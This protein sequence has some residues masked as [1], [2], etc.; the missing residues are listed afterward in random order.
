M[1]FRFISSWLGRTSKAATST[2]K[3]HST[4]EMIDYIIEGSE[5]EIAGHYDAAERAFRRALTITPNN[6]EALYL[7]GKQMARRG[8]YAGSLE[9]LD[10]ALFENPNLAEARLLVANVYLS[11]QNFESAIAIYQSFDAQNSNDQ[12]LLNNYGLA[13]LGLKKY[14]QARETLLKAVAVNPES[15][16]AH[17]N[18]GL[19]FRAQGE[20]ALAEKWFRDSLKLNPS[21]NEAVKHL[22]RI[23]FQQ[24]R[25]TEAL[26]ITEQA[27]FHDSSTVEAHKM[28]GFAFFTLGNF[29]EAEAKLRKVTSL[30]PDE[31]SLNYLAR[32]LQSCRRFEEAMVFY[33]KS[34]Q[35]NP[36]Y[37]P[38]AWHRSLLLLQTRDYERGWIDYEHRLSSEDPHVRQF[39]S[40]Q[41]DGTAL[42]DAQLLVYAEQ[43]LGDQIMFAS[44]I[45]EATRLAKYVTIECSAKLEKLFRRSFPK[46]RVIGTDNA[47]P[48]QWIDESPD[49]ATVCPIGSLPKFFRRNAKEFPTHA[50]YLAADPQR[51]LHWK[52]LLNNLGPGLKVGISWAGGTEKS[53]RNLRS[54]PLSAWLPILSVPNAQFVSLQY[55]VDYSTLT[56]Q[57]NNFDT[58][59]HHWQ[60]TIDD[61]DETAAL[62]CALD[63]IISVQTA[64]IHLCGA[65][66]RPTWVMVPVCA[67]WRYGASGEA[68]DWYPSV[69]LF[70]QTDFN[71]WDDVLARVRSELKI[72][73][74]ALK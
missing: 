71:N 22:C 28:A 74:V 13:L 5:L 40:P 50:G 35:I 43:G 67:E 39:T 32:T 66:G 46:L 53:R 15:I 64:I 1:F 55:D 33:N 2:S 34:L 45:T 70:R 47:D 12:A 21:N 11:M 16:E 62:A 8:N 52:N 20:T 44:C 69:R 3:P 56:K 68:M 38:A 4:K 9:L 19:A 7:I 65:L 42:F 23:L 29:P 63:L 31:E 73:T 51:V 24:N 27:I 26:T 60:E 6:A 36:N 48:Q 41:W 72:K 18:I 14:T 37:V 30:A 59:I 10:A 49:I 58:K 57:T 61:Y 54:I 25:T 17:I